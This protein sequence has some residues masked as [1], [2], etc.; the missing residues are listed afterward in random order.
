LTVCLVDWE[1]SGAA[2]AAGVAAA[3]HEAHRVCRSPD[4]DRVDFEGGVWVRRLAAGDR[5]VPELDGHPQRDTLCRAAAVYREVDRIH[6]RGALDAVVAPGVG[7]EALLCALDDRFT[8][9]QPS[10]EE[11]PERLLELCRTAVADSDRNAP[12]PPVSEFPGRTVVAR[13][14]ENLTR[15]GLPRA[16]AVRAADTLL[17]PACYPVDYPARTLRLWEC[18]DEVF[19]RGL[20]PLLLHREVDAPTEARYLRLLRRGMPRLAVVEHIARSREAAAGGLPLAWLALMRRLAPRHPI[21]VG[22]LD[23]LR[24]LATRLVWAAKRRFRRVNGES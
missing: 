18:P 24:T 15:A 14:A 17:D 12:R 6:A 8:T 23:R 3:G 20:F 11:G 10:P 5:L 1:G 7:G 22:L 4:T 21:R 19:L 13:L 2:L 9:L 16:D